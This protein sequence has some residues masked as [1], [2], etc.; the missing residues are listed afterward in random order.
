MHKSTVEATRIGSDHKGKR[1]DRG[2]GSVEGVVPLHPRHQ[3]R[4]QHRE[5]R[6]IAAQ[7]LKP[8]PPTLSG[9]IKANSEHAR[10][11]NWSTQRFGNGTLF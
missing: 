3:T 5:I 1:Q 10:E 6:G 9:F 4:L 7:I 8:Q 11:A 2:E